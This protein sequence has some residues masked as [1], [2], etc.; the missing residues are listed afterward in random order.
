MHLEEVQ[1]KGDG[2]FISQDKYVADILKKFDFVTVKTSST[3][4]RAFSDSDYVG[5][6]LD[7]KS[8]TRGCQFLSK[9]L[10]SWQCKKQTIV[11]NST[12]EA[13]YVASANCYGQD[14]Q[15]SMVRFGEMR[16]LEVLRLILEEI[17]Y[18]CMLALQAKEGE[19]SGNPSEPQP[20]PSIA[21][22]THEEPIP[23]IKSSSS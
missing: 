11:A 3:H 18:N 7:R 2:I 15:S 1:Q 20:P 12:T 21:Q 10:I 22:P 5:A 16:Q 13:E 4:I 9:N 17:G 14:G 19:D 6:S 8:T 23:N